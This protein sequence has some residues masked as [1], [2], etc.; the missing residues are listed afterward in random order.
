[1]PVEREP[2]YYLLQWETL[3]VMETAGPPV[4]AEAPDVPSV[5]EMLGAHLPSPCQPP[6]KGVQHKGWFVHFYG[7]WSPTSKP[8]GCLA[9]DGSSTSFCH[10]LQR[11]LLEQH[12]DK[13]V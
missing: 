6:Q 9:V 12:L 5:G 1:M 7:V 11:S 10:R 13:L 4:T 2:L 3:G 8:W